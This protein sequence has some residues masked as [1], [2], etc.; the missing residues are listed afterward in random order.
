MN[1]SYHLFCL[2]SFPPWTN[3]T[4]LMM[5]CPSWTPTNS[6]IN[7]EVFDDY[8]YI[9]LF[10]NHLM[11]FSCLQFDQFFE[12]SSEYSWNDMNQFHRIFFRYFSF[13]ETK[14]WN[15][16]AWLTWHFFDTINVS[17]R[18]DMSLFG[19][20]KIKSWKYYFRFGILYKWKN[21]VSLHECGFSKDIQRKS[22]YCYSHFPSWTNP[23]ICQ[24]WIVSLGT[25]Q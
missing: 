6:K 20:L 5:F 16:N 4:T 7:I 2:F 3:A 8:H 12:K 22:C 21:F 14:L 1:S 15:V 19:S 13:V 17:P 25:N 24:I 9:V 10:S 11:L 23:Q 18:S